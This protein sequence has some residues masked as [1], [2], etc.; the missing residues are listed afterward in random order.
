MQV[1]Y[2]ISFFGFFA[3]ILYTTYH[4]PLAVRHIPHSI[5]Y[6]V[7]SYC[8][9]SNGN[10]F[11]CLKKEIKYNLLY[12]NNIPHRFP[13][14]KGG[15]GEKRKLGKLFP[16][17]SLGES[18]PKCISPGCPREGVSH[19]RKGLVHVAPKPPSDGKI[20]PTPGSIQKVI[21]AITVTKMPTFLYTHKVLIGDVTVRRLVLCRWCA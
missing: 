14:K 12:T 11:S 7:S 6:G 10:H 13:Q 3:Y 15:W 16:A 18:L 9:C 5:Y 4:T 1:Q 2:S 20:H 17:L 19:P 21:Q 8:T